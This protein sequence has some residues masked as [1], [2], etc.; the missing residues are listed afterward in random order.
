MT[1]GGV[2]PNIVSI[3]NNIFTPNCALSGCHTQ[4]APR[5]ALDL[6]FGSAQANLINVPAFDG[7]GFLRVQPGNAVDS[8]LYMKLI[9]DMRIVGVRMPKDN[10]PLSAEELT[11]VRDWIVGGSPTTPGY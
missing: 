5:N 11:A 4:P 10:P 7:S 8:Y 1:P 3:Q 9:G 6:T 2:Q